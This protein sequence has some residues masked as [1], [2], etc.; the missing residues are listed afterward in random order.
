MHTI[1]FEMK[2]L[3]TQA[4]GLGSCGPGQLSGPITPIFC[5]LLSRAGFPGNWVCQ[6][7]IL[8]L[9]ISISADITSFRR[10][11]QPDPSIGLEGGRQKSR[12]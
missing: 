3:K 4:I 1:A 12:V 6:E 9:A 10:M 7:E 11:V 8:R 5:L 2:E